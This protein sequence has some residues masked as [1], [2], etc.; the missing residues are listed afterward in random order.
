MIFLGFKWKFQM[1]ILPLRTSALAWHSAAGKNWVWE[2]RI[3][4]LQPE[5]ALILILILILRPELALRDKKVWSPHCEFS[6]TWQWTKWG[7]MATVRTMETLLS[8]QIIVRQRRKKVYRDGGT[9]FVET[10]NCATEKKKTTYKDGGTF[11][12]KTNY[13]ATEAKNYKGMVVQHCVPSP[14]CETQRFTDQKL[15]FPRIKHINTKIQ[16]QNTKM[17]KYQIQHMTKCQKD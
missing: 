2:L 6:R 12:V 16:I 9:F 14:N 7:G 1:E 10:N 8:R 15:I 5:L 3:N 17:H 4:W 13:C 11:F